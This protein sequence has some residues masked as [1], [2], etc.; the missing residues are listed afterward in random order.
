M[1]LPVAPPV[2]LLEKLEL[3]GAKVVGKDGVEVCV[4]PGIPVTSGV[5]AV[6]C[7]IGGSDSSRAAPKLEVGL[8]GFNPAMPVICGFS[9]AEIEGAEDVIV[10]PVGWDD[11]G[12]NEENKESWKVEPVVPVMAVVPVM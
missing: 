8:N 7:G 4:G 6:D 1:R 2:G 3:F 12:E 10:A 5:A 11:S 9:G